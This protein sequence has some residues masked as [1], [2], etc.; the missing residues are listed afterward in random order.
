[1]TRRSRGGGPPPAG[2]QQEEAGEAGGGWRLRNWRLRSKL[3]AVLL[4]PTLA[5]VVLV[6][7]R[8]RSD[9]AQATRFAEGA[10]RVQVDQRVAALVHRLQRE[11]DLS[12]R[13]VAAD[14]QGDLAEL[15]T[16][17]E[18]V[19]AAVG[20]F[21]RALAEVRPRLSEQAVASFE[22][23]EDRLGTLIGLRYASEHSAL[24]ST[25]VRR[26]YGELIT[27][28]LDIGDQAAAEP[29]DRKLTRTR[30]ATNALAR[31]KDLMSVKRAVVAEGL[32]R[33]N[34]SEE[35]QRALLGAEAELAAARNDF[36]KLATPEQRRM[37]DDTVIGLVVDNGNDMV[38]AVLNRTENGE[39][40][41]G[42]DPRRWETA[43]T[44]TVNLANQVQEAMLV[45]VQQRSDLLATRAREDAI[46][47]AGVMLGVLIVAGILAA[48]VARSL[49][50]PLRTLRRSALEVAGHRLPAAVD[51]ILA[52]PDPSRE[53]R[54]GVAPV[55]VFSR[56]ELGQVARAFDAVHGEA[57]RLAGEQALLREN[58]NSMFANLSRR[59]QELVERQL[60]VLDRMEADEQDPETLGGL[61][62][63]D[64]LAT[65][66]RRN[67][68]NL[69]VLS[70]QDLGPAA[71]GAAATDEI[72]GAALSEVEHYRRIEVATTPAFAVRG[73][74]VSD[75]VHVVSELLEN[76]TEYSPPDTMVSVASSITPDGDWRI[77]ITDRGAG[78]PP[79]EIRRANTRLAEPPEVD[80]EVSRRMGL[81]VVA[82]L[83]RRHD[84]RVRLAESG[85]GG[86]TATVIVPAALLGAPPPPEE[87]SPEPAEPEPEPVEEA[88]RE[89]VEPELQPEPE[90]EPESPLARSLAEHGPPRRAP[91]EPE[92]PPDW[93][94]EDDD[95]AHPLEDDVPTERMPAYQA[96]LAQWFQAVAAGEED[97]DRSGLDALTR[98]RGEPAAED[99]GGEAE[100]LA[101]AD[102]EEIERLPRPSD[103]ITVPEQL[104]QEPRRWPGAED[105]PESYAWPEDSAAAG[106]VPAERPA[107]DTGE[108]VQDGG[109]TAAGLPRRVP[110]EGRIPSATD[111]PAMDE[112]P[113]ISMAPEAVRLRMASLQ[114]GR[115]RGRHQR[116][117]ERSTR[118]QGR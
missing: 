97:A 1:M 5:V 56:E 85:Q 118:G 34:L 96:V 94:T 88:E 53:G 46:R 30:L 41:T 114:S 14:R 64:H 63:L 82:R 80:V 31:V 4:I 37:Y 76:A 3:L 99:T 8:I 42:L 105:D 33:G 35:G 22:Q 98:I 67:S 26:S 25:G 111:T 66:M 108:T 90:P 48:V 100:D 62:E 16:Q 19:N 23:T 113:V 51:E 18:R 57:V 32:A 28:L 7:L 27:G 55:P 2:R 11:R 58:V 78:M 39:P 15:N 117:V 92:S 87:V 109:L 69:L 89:P 9:L 84:I 36:G 112:G 110:R 77:D 71:A 50:R 44:Y 17:R 75:L 43:A 101:E 54:R 86:L 65:R 103:P 12:V 91:V 70:G 106:A 47:G 6:G 93:P 72:I 116:A 95:D 81:Y 10:T 61:F 60:S 59:S 29:T 21:D 13:Y 38:E 107:A 102:T 49:L 115:Q 104:W 79:T 73:D 45:Q 83:A 20:E 24:P 40:L 52:D 68:E 74:A